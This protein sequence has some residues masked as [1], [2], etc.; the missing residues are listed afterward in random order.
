[1][2]RS[3]AGVLRMI[4]MLDTRPQWCK[5]GRF[6]TPIAIGAAAVA[7]AIGGRSKRR[8]AGIDSGGGPLSFLVFE[9]RL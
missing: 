2:G 3:G 4:V 6:T 5:E 8:G 7:V 1:M 9:R